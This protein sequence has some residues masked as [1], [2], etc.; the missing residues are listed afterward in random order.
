MS[1][2]LTI[3]DAERILWELSDLDNETA[4]LDH[5]SQICEALDYLTSQ[6]DYLIFGVC[7]D[8]VAEALLVL[9]KYTSYF[10][11]E[12]PS[13]DLPLINDGVYLKYNPRRPRYHCDSYKGN[14][15]GVLLSFHT[16]FTD[17]YS[18]THGHFPLD[19]F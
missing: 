4:T 8:T 15:R 6:A 5:R 1:N 2:N 13:G 12:L 7:A 16:D 19:L 17:G 9:K 10:H 11:Y 14:Y 3:N 18:G